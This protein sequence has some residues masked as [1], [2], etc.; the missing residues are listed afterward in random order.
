M[1]LIGSITEGK[2][3]EELLASKQLV[4]EDRLP[5]VSKC[6]R[7]HRPG[8]ES[9]LILE[10][11]PEQGEDL[12]VVLLDGREVATLELERDGTEQSF[13]TESAIE[14]ERTLKGR[15][16]RLRLAVALDIVRTR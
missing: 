5:G 12:Y 14:Y 7:R 6:L 10:W 15:A 16:D 4:E 11:T 2:I 13:A 8:F 9:A 3:R 1:K